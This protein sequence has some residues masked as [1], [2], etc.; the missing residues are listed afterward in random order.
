MLGT[1]AS[2]NG[3][4]GKVDVQMTY[5][6]EETNGQMLAGAG[7]TTTVTVTGVMP[8]TASVMLCYVQPWDWNGDPASAAGTAVYEFEVY[9]D[10]SVKSHASVVT[11]P[12][13]LNPAG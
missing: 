9:K 2:L 4:T 1:P 11:L 8:G 7:G 6:P 12:E 3:D 5:M 13:G 10:L